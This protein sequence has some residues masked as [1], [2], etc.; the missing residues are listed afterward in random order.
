MIDGQDVEPLLDLFDGL[1][2][3]PAVDFYV[4]TCTVQRYFCCVGGGGP[5]TV[6]GRI[7]HAHVDAVVAQIDGVT[8]GHRDSLG[9]WTGQ[10]KDVGVRR[11]GV[12]TVI[13]C[14]YNDPVKVFWL[15]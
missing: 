4:G 8:A 9:G 15:T 13:I 5:G 10:G 11:C 6:G 14:C 1:Y 2:Q 7:A 3:A 12:H